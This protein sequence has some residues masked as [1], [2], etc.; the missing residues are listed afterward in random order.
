MRNSGLIALEVVGQLNQ[1]SIDSQ[2]IIRNYALEDELSIEQLVRI[3]KEQGFK[4]KIKTLSPLQ[5]S[6]YPLPCIAQNK[7]GSYVSI[8]KIDIQ[9]EQ[10]LVFSTQQKE[11]YALSFQEFE[12]SM[13]ARLIILKHKMLTDQIKFGFKWFY[14][15]ILHYKRI[16][17]EILLASFVIQLF[18][19]VTPLF[20]QVIL[21]KVLVHHSLSTLN[22]IAVA[23]GAVILFD[24]LLNLSRNYIFAHTTSKIDARLG[25][26]LFRHLISLPLVYFEKR[27]VGNIIARVRELD[28]IR[29]FIAN[30]SITIL[31]D[32]LFSVV[33]VAMMMVYSVKLAFIALGFIFVIAILYFFVTPKLRQRLEEKFQMGAQSNSYLVESVTGMQTVKSLAIEGSMQ[34]NGKITLENM[35]IRVLV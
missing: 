7:D 13:N 12:D 10:M 1:I 26:R 8:L 24:L 21:D 23:F 4:A 18:G 17:G 28:Q 34:K 14:D 22:V 30:K 31:L 5:M 20:T 3:A 35:L 6:K 19:L 9:K 15:Q 27:K 16:V 33:F 32:I 2:A 29:E 11:P 25:A